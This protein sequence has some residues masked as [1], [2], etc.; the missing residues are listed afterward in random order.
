MTDDLCRDV[1]DCWMKE[2]ANKAV[3]GEVQSRDGRAIAENT[4]R[5]RM[6]SLLSDD[7]CFEITMVVHFI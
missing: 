3:G 1:T 5:K 4:Y 2:A 7:N 6:E